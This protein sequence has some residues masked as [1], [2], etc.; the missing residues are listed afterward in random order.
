MIVDRGHD[1]PAWV[2]DSLESYGTA[3]W[4]FRNQVNLETTKAVN[5]YRGDFR[6]CDLVF[7]S[8]TYILRSSSFNY[9]TP[10]VRLTPKDLP[11]TS[12]SDPKYLHFICSPQRAAEILSEVQQIDGWAPIC[13]YEP[14]PVSLFPNLWRT[15]RNLLSSR[16]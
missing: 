5:I 8:A 14:I 7:L 2:Q 1:F 4:L 15:Q 9:L 11:S 10:R 6:G 12:L 13:I 16:R 3:M